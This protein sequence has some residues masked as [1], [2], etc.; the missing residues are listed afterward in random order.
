MKS[1]EF[2]HNILDNMCAVTLEYIS[3]I[4][5]TLPSLLLYS[6]QLVQLSNIFKIQLNLRFPFAK[7]LQKKAQ[8]LLLLHYIFARKKSTLRNCSITS[9]LAQNFAIP[10]LHISVLRN[11]VEQIIIKRLIKGVTCIYI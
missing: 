7:L 10:L 2:L 9:F 6:L 5:C 8:I 3:N 4:S 11:L 1:I